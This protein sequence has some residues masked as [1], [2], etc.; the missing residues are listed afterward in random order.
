MIQELKDRITKKFGTVTHFCDCANLDIYE[1]QKLFT[2]SIR[3]ESRESKREPK[4]WEI[5]NICDLTNADSYTVKQ[6][7]PDMRQVIKDKINALGGVSEYVKNNHEFSESTIRQIINGRRK[8]I[9]IGVN[10]LLDKLEIKN[11]EI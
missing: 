9:S 2:S 6:I 10:L 4:L 3:A 8:N 7:S 11:H 5:S 1:V